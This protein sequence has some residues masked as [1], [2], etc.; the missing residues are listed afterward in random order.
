MPILARIA[1]SADHAR[2]NGYIDRSAAASVYHRWEWGEIFRE[3]YGTHPVY[4]IAER[5]GRV[6]GVLPMLSLK[7]GPLGTDL[8][9]LPYFG[10]AGALADDDEA[11]HALVG[12]A[13]DAARELG[14]RHIE[15][16]HAHPVP[17]GHLPRRDD[18]VL[19]HLALPADIDELARRLGSKVRADVR[20][21]Q[22]E[23]MVAEIGGKDLVGDFHAVYATVMRDLGSPCH[24]R[25]LFE[26]IFRRL[27]ER[28]FIVRVLY[29]HRTVGAA[30]LIGQGSVLEVPCA[31]TLHALNKLRAN[32]LL[33]WTALCAA[34]ERGYATF[35]FGR[36]TIDAGTYVFKKN[37]GAQAL[38]LPY[39]YLLP[40]GR[41][42]PRPHADH[43]ALARASAFW[44]RLPL[45]LAN[46]LGPRIVRHLA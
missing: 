44:R 4:V 43:R 14:A 24:A 2:W 46:A 23:G 5:E 32:M 25:A 40:E 8:V 37:W 45:P 18:K 29:E 21:P 31:G 9:S 20:R 13:R 42:V 34:I 19:M 38:P 12:F 6:V 35:S 28:C 33:Y 11:W 7:R 17:A 3:V 30:F 10:H 26:E 22:K 15:L 36:S 41:E 1:V 16:R 39:H 27:P